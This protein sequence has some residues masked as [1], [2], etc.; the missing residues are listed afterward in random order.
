MRYGDSY[1]IVK[2]G[3]HDFWLC[4]FRDT[5]KFTEHKHEAELF[6]NQEVAL[7]ALKRL[8][9]YPPNSKD[10]E[11]VRVP[12]RVVLI[13]LTLSESGRREWFRHEPRLFIPEHPNDL[14]RGGL[15]EEE[16]KAGIP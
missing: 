4:K 2:H 16:Y 15:T 3:T 12:T 8:Y 5:Y 6:V 7:C 10:G 1:V 13:I 9:K 14:T 11:K